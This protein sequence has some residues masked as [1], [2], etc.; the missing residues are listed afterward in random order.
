MDVRLGGGDRALRS[1]SS[2][3]EPGSLLRCRLRGVQSD[4]APSDAG[5]EGGLVVQALRVER[6]AGETV[7]AL[8]AAGREEAEGS[9]AG[10][11]IKARWV[12]GPAGDAGKGAEAAQERRRME[13]DITAMEVAV[14]HETVSLARALRAAV[15]AGFRS[16]AQDSAGAAS[17]LSPRHALTPSLFSPRAECTPS[18]AGAP[19]EELSLAPEDVAEE[20][21]RPGRWKLSRGG[22]GGS[23]VV[24][25]RSGGVR[26]R[27]VGRGGQ[28]VFAVE[29]DTVAFLRTVRGDLSA[30]VLP[31]PASRARLLR[32]PSVTHRS[33]K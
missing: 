7:L 19:P 10:H 3:E 13:V 17:V 31:S 4:W 30:S 28:Q 29:M 11:C 23:D 8:E 2:R 5:A 1:A 21:G 20:L 18:G 24:R 6:E 9:A 25:L 22:R 14:E 26:L 33:R 27:C 32:S 15:D 12:V 16:G